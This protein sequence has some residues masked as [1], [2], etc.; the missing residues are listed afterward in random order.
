MTL[1]MA[2]TVKRLRLG[3]KFVYVA[4]AGRCQL[5]LF[6][7]EIKKELIYGQC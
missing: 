3:E 5:E 1:E 4:W 6:D 2:I 7:E